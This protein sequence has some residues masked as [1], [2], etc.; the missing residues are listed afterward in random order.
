MARKE[1]G[2]MRGSVANIIFYEREGK[3][4]MR[5][6]PTRVRQTRATRKSAGQFGKAAQIS[7]VLREGLS[8][9]LYNSKERGLMHRLNNALLQWLLDNGAGK[10]KSSTHLPFINGFQLYQ[11][12]P[13]ESRFKVPLSVNWD[14]QNLVTLDIPALIPVKHISAPAGTKTVR[15]EIGITDC[16]LKDFTSSGN[17]ITVIEIPYNSVKIP[18]QQVKLPF[19]RKPGRIA[20]VALALKNGPKSKWGLPGKFNEKWEPAG[21]VGASY[22]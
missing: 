8:P 5:S 3:E 9:I 11:E 21:I 13:L 4:C 1:K 20:L 22:R 7:R 10:I 12:T 16:A 15:L 18:A 6:K 17:H 14:G 19:T 2:F